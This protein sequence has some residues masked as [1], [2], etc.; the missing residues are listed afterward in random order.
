MTR[1]MGYPRWDQFDLEEAPCD[2]CGNKDP[3]LLYV[4][5]DG[6]KIVECSCGLVYANPRPKLEEINKI[7]SENYFA[8]RSPEM[9]YQHYLAEESV[10]ELQL[11]AKGRLSVLKQHAE[12]AGKRVL[13]IGCA[14]GEAS[15]LASD[16]GASTVGCDQSFDAIRVARKRYPGVEFLEGSIEGLGSTAVDFD[17]VMAWE[18][19]EHLSS[20]SAFLRAISS[21][22]LKKNGLL[23]LSTPNLEYGRLIGW[24]RWSGFQ[25]SFEHLYFFSSQSLRNFLSSFGFSMLG[26]YSYGSG[27]VVNGARSSAENLLKKLLYEAG[28]LSTL[29]TFR[30]RFVPSKRVNYV[31][32]DLGHWLLCVAEK[33]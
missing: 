22:L 29:Q 30:D 7:Y 8:A 23:A 27:I 17:I 4:R 16:F 32:G 28:L 1:D 14:T 9:G 33:Q 26:I 11:F 2:F 15:K 19:V 18:V 31:E 13:E 5:P 10:V 12:F 20:P 25:T 24:D 6:A 3:L 21:R